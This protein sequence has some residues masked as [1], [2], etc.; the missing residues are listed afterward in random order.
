VPSETAA[1][2][3]NVEGAGRLIDA[4]LGVVLL[5]GHDA[6]ARAER[7]P[8]RVLGVLRALR[9][10]LPDVLIHEVLERGAVGLE[11]GGVGVRQIVG[12]DCH[13]RVLCVETGLGGP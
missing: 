11:A 1:A 10:H 12:N 7:E 4:A 2:D 13:P 5:G 8:G 6:H 9:S 3:R